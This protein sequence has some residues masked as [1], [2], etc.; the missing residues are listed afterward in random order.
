MSLYLVLNFTSSSNWFLLFLFVFYL[1]SYYSFCHGYI[2]YVGSVV[3][4]LI[5][6]FIS[7]L[8]IRLGSTIVSYLL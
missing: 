1:Y 6:L 2:S 4:L 3:L 5:V 7:L 8:T